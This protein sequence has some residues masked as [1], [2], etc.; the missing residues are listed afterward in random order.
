M[1]IYTKKLIAVAFV[2]ASAFGFSQTVTWTN[3]N[4]TNIFSDPL[5]WNTS[6]TP[7]STDNVVF[8]GTSSA[9]CTLDV[10]IDVNSMSIN[11]GYGGIVDAASTNPIIE[12]AFTQAAGTF[13]S[14]DQILTIGGNMTSTGGTFSHMNGA[15][16]IFINSGASIAMSGTWN[17]NSL[18]I[19]VTGLGSTQRTMDFGAGGVTTA[20]LTLNSTTK[21]YTYKGTVNITGDLSIL[22]TNTGNPTG[23]TGVFN[24]TGAG[25]ISITGTGAVARNKIA[26]VTMN[27][28]GAVSLTGHINMMGTWLSTNVGS[29]TSGSSNVNFYGASCAITGGITAATT[30]YMDNVSIQSG[31]T[32]GITNGTLLDM[33]GSF[34]HSGTFNANTSS[35]RFSGAS[36]HSVAGTATLTT[37]NGVAQTGAGS[38]S[39][40]HATNIL[41]SIRING[42][43]VNLTNITLKSTSSLK[44]R[45]AEISGGGSASGNMTVETFIP[46]GTTDWAVLGASGVS[47]LTFN[48]WYGQIPM[49][50]EGSTTGVTSSGGQ[51]FESVQG[52]NEADAYGYDTTITVTSPIATGKG[53]WLFVGTGLSSTSNITTS[54]SGPVVSGSQSIG[55]SKSAQSGSCLLA[56]PFASPI[57]WDKINAANPGV[58]TGAIYVYNAD[59][60]IT[61]SY[62]GGISTPNSPQ[63]ISSTIPMGQGF[64]VVANGAG[65]LVISESSKVSNNTSANP[66]LKTT[67]TSSSS[68]V[69]S[70][71]YLQLTD[72][73]YFDETAIRFHGA[74]TPGYDN[75][76]DAIKYFDSPGY[77]G[78]PGIWTARTTI[79][80]QGPGV[81]YS[82]NSLPYATSSNA[83][84]PVLARV[85][86]SGQHTISANNLSDLPP[87]TCVVLKD[88]LLNVTQD[89]SLGNYVCNIMDTTTTAR[90]ELTVCGNI[91]LGVNNIQAAVSDNVL[92]KQ[93]I[94][95]VYVD[96]NFDSK[97]TSYITATNVLGQQIMNPKQ[98]ECVSGKYYLDLNAKDQVVLVSVVANNKRT[99]KKFFIANQN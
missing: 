12:T 74:A 76:L 20:S 21:L 28:T 57:S 19:S 67:S 87:G 80:T 32:L 46:G 4:G 10:D 75:N 96:L 88:K 11:V 35:V 41:D 39:F 17:F 38:L 66:L 15:V 69:G 23:N 24:F 25:P 56:N 97:T 84:I 18:I 79:S 65:P 62:A 54:V 50:I 49:A 8:D 73:T 5:N 48:S 9:N 89:L 92:I 61:T 52:W 30:A 14:T 51:Y 53:Y 63:A 26:N 29:F 64:Y 60:G 72:G 7:I 55:L 81:D 98:V 1:K 91:A 68:T 95:G 6:T 99:T 40:S 93:D 43:A 45:L 27:T 94:N 2:F 58:T 77:I 70:V 16:E 59:L 34:T 44:G 90:F 78:Y 47:G 86:A 31:A 33:S 13:K 71:I 85:Y 36:A 42:G 3:G 83:V 22:G 37:F 82:I